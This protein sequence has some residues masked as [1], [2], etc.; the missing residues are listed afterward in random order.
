MRAIGFEVDISVRGVR[1]IQHSIMRRQSEDNIY[2]LSMDRRFSLRSVAIV[3]AIIAAV[4]AAFAVFYHNRR[5]NDALAEIIVWAESPHVKTARMYR[6]VITNDG[7]LISYHGHSL[8]IVRLERIGRGYHARHEPR[9]TPAW[10]MRQRRRTSLSEEEFLHIS[11]LANR[12][13]LGDPTRGS[14]VGREHIMLMHNGN[15]Y[16]YGSARCIALLELMDTVIR[17][18]PL[19][20]R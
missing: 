11:D 1:I 18:S 17:L 5:Y 9:Y 13:L 7:A 12:S 2:S 10:L 6:F 14:L 4:T 15:I 3:F 8:T 19:T 16:V 20:I